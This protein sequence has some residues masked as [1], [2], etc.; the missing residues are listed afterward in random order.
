MSS[1]CCVRMAAHST[2]ELKARACDNVANFF[3][4]RL[5]ERLSLGQSAIN[6]Q[7]LV[8]SVRCSS[9]CEDA[10]LIHPAFGD[11]MLNAESC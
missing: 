6:A 10:A 5:I 1:M 3:I 9:S 8:E 11:E 2:M 4:I 7:A